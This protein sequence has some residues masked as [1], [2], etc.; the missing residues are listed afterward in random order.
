VPFLHAF[1]QFD[2]T[3]D[4][5]GEL[6]WVMNENLLRRFPSGLRTLMGRMSTSKA[7]LKSLRVAQL[8]GARG[9]LHPMDWRVEAEAPAEG[10]LRTTWTQ[11]GALQALRA[12]GEDGVFPYAC[13]IDYL[14][15]NLMGIRFNRTKTLADGD[16]CCNNDIAG[17]GFTEWAPEKGFEHRR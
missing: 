1:K 12:I 6:L 3:R 4:R 9:L 14:M 13:R 5:A 2:E 16:D 7:M 10:G 15:A 11:C 8:R 17:P